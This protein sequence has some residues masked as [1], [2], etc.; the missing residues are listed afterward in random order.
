MNG[1]K[2]NGKKKEAVKYADDDRYSVRVLA[3][4]RIPTLLLG[5]A[6]GV[7]MSFVTSRFEEVLSQNV[8][9]AFFIP[10]IVYMA[11]A[12]GSQ[13]RDIYVRDLK[14]GRARFRTY[15]MKESFLGVILGL[16]FGAASWI[17]VG[18]WFG[19]GDLAKTVGLAMFAAVAVAPFVAL[20]VAEILQLERQDPAIGAGPIAT[21]ILDTISVVIYGLVASVIFL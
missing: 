10:L 18:L 3:L 17:I 5:L 4:M 6:L 21:V 12:V 9:I 16:L 14:S 20:L 7:A 19:Y 1:E 2:G 15:A 11:D 8:A 13:T